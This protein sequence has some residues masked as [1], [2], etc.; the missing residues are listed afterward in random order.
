MK[1]FLSMRDLESE[2]ECPDCGF[3]FQFNLKQVA[4]GEV[5]KCKSCGR[6]IELVDES[7]ECKKLEKSVKDL[8]KSF[9]DLN[10]L[11]G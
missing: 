8:N 4:K 6:D 9:G 5:I 7:N 2:A 10:K 3:K 11:F 1:E